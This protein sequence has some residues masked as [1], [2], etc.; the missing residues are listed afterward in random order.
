M[1][2]RAIVFDVDGVL[3]SLHS[4]Y[5]GVYRE[6]VAEAF[7]SF[8]V[9]PPE[10]ELDAF[11][12]SATIDGMSA[13]C[14]RHGLDFETFWARREEEVSALQRRMMVRGERTPYD[15]CSTLPELANSHALG[16]VSSNQHA[17]IRH[18][19]EHFEFESHF[20]TSYGREPTVEGFR[21]VKPD[22]HYLERALEDLGTR[23][24]LYVGDST[25]DVVAAN[26][27]GLDSAF[28]WRSHRDGYELDAEPTYEIDSLVELLDI[29][30]E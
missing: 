14:E 13:V 27:A 29:A 4:D 2:Y 3:L 7:R 17:T 12:G 20:E 8:G 19:L 9:E 15:D 6:G 1:S 5:P 30:A 28:L 23:S 22:V 26:E 25:C 18:M 11:V 24:A 16:I 21:R 10:T